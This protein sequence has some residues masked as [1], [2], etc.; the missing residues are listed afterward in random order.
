MNYNM[1]MKRIFL[2]LLALL[3]SFSASV[4]SIVVV[5]GLSHEH[6]LRGTQ[7]VQGNIVL[8][9][10][11]DK[12]KRAKIYKTD[13]E[14]SCNGETE[15][16]EK[17]IRNRCNADWLTLSDN[18]VIL[19]A[20]QTITITYALSP[21]ETIQSSGSYWSAI[22]IEEMEDLDTTR[23]DLGVKVNALVRYA[24]QIIG[25]Y[26]T[27]AV[28]E[29]EFT[30]YEYDTARGMNRVRVGINNTGNYMMKPIVVL[31]I[32][33]DIGE[34]VARKEIPYQKVYPGYC[35]LFDI[36]LHDVPAGNYN[37]ILVAD[38]GDENIYGLKIEEIDI[39]QTTTKL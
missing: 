11:G 3:F 15:F 13:V 5:N 28:K 21:W 12:Q 9:N 1:K 31:E 32:Y 33:N 6:T 22:M 10:T 4:A 26:E 25:S 38:C 7:K 37:G 29:L 30:N 36:S 24:I 18:E 14:H 34:Q 39:I 35:K 17:L 19:Q 2:S 16:G 8:R 27:D 20:G 23:P